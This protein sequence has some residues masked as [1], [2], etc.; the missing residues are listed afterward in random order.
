VTL[1]PI[2]QA[3]EQTATQ[4][5]GAAPSVS[6]TQIAGAPITTTTVP[7]PPVTVTQAPVASADTADAAVGSATGTTVS[8]LSALPVGGADTGQA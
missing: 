7:E 3:N 8:S 5:A 2:A 1:P 4:D 6:C